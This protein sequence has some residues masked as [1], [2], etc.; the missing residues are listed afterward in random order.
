MEQ[1]HLKR[2]EMSIHV[3]YFLHQLFVYL[4]SPDSTETDPQKLRIFS[5]SNLDLRDFFA[6]I[7]PDLAN[8]MKGFFKENNPGYKL[9]E[10]KELE[11]VLTPFTEKSKLIPHH[12]KC[13]CSFSCLSECG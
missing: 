11:D 7:L 9:K 12:I 10:V 6:K 3:F 2:P 8:Y 5:K 4:K 1:Y 13:E